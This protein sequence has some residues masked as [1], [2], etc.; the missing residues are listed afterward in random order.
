MQ[1]SKSETSHRNSEEK[2]KYLFLLSHFLRVTSAEITAESINKYGMRLKSNMFAQ[3]LKTCMFQLWFGLWV[4]F[5]TKSYFRLC[6]IWLFDWRC[7]KLDYVDRVSV[8]SPVWTQTCWW[9]CLPGGFSFFFLCWI[10]C[11]TVESISDKCYHT[12]R[13]KSGTNRIEQAQTNRLS[14]GSNPGERWTLQTPVNKWTAF[15]YI[16]MFQVHN[17]KWCWHTSTANTNPK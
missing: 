16:N 17:K 10:L 11:V 4:A 1:W 7:I 14:D 2:H 5:K 12:D 6:L 3:F 9:S 8:K 13:V 15:M